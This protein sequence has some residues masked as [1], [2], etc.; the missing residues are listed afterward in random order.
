MSK[1]SGQD[2]KTDTQWRRFTYTLLLASG[3]IPAVLYLFIVIVDPYDNLP[4]SPDWE[5]L[6][7]TGSHRHYKPSVARRSEYEGV[8]IGASTS[9]MLHPGRLGKALDARFANLAMPAA[10]PF[11]QLRLL[12]L[13][14][15]HH[16]T[17]RYVFVGLDPVYCD[18]D[19]AGKQLGANKGRP[20]PYWLYDENHWNDW[21]GLTPES[22]KHARRQARA[23]LQPDE[24]PAARDGYY[25]FTIKSYGPYDLQHARK[26]IYKG[27]HPLPKPQ[28]APSV[29]IDPATRQGWLFPDLIQLQKALEQ[30]PVETVKL[31]FFTPLHWYQQAQPGTQEQVEMAE[32]KHRVAAFA[33][34]LK[35]YY[36]LDF[37]RRTPIT[38]EDSNYW[39]GMHF[40]TEIARSLE[41]IL[42]NVIKG[43]QGDKENYTH[44][45]SPSAEIHPSMH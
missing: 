27:L 30:L 38:L 41:D 40:T 28:N 6:Q 4:V 9:M 32:C 1:T 5:R 17:P 43:V 39:D 15:D 12:R 7:I 37:M 29:N 2:E 19:G 34:R 13:Y 44:L 36:A 14:R 45:A 24:D 42:A 23:L 35:N 8:V 25:N 11:E 26:N 22:L 16:P 3:A 31:V 20:D 21:P 10:S 18:P 33:D